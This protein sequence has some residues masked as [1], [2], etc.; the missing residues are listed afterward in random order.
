MLKFLKAMMKI[1]KFEK[2]YNIKTE[3]EYYERRIERF[4]YE[5]ILHSIL[6]DYL[7]NQGDLVGCVNMFFNSYENVRQFEIY[8]NGN[9]SIRFTNPKEENQTG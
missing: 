7:L 9:L 6:M 8:I 5:E 1:G 4:D 2:D 3:F